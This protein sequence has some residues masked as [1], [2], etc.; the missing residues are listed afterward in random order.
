MD[1]Y[2]KTF[3][4]RWAECDANGHVRN[5]A[6]SEYAVDVRLDYCTEH[7]FGFD[8]MR[9]AGIGPIIVREEI[10]YLR[11]LRMGESVRVDLALLGLSPECARFRFAHEFAKEDGTLCARIVLDG[12]WL[13][14]RSRK[15][16][17][18]PDRLAELLRAMP[19]G[20]AYSELPALRT[21]G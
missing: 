18:P 11:E 20:E 15:L 13:D 14:L 6:Y 4:V 21:R 2:A 3:T 8:R 19:R 5:T 9:E 1:P 12:G 7:G 16:A 17:A 10:D